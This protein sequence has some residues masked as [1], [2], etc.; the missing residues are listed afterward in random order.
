[1]PSMIVD[2]VGGLLGADKPDCL[3]LAFARLRGAGWGA[4][5]AAGGAAGGCRAGLAGRQYEW[6]KWKHLNF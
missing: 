5:A 6:K 1:M 4:A 3:L 2:V